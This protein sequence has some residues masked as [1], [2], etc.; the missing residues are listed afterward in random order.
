MS[1]L[2]ESSEVEEEEEKEEDKNIFGGDG[3][4]K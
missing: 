4:I 3:K 1:S 2:N